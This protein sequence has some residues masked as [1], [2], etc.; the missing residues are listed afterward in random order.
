MSLDVEG[1]KKVSGL[2]IW[3]IVWRGK[4]EGEEEE[5]GSDKGVYTTRGGGGC[6][7]PRWLYWVGSR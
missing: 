5:E 4:E 3:R 2:L 7:G 1:S 6:T